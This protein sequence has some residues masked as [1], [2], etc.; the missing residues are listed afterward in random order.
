MA[1]WANVITAVKHY[2]AWCNMISIKIY[3][4]QAFSGTGIKRS[5]SQRHY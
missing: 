3:C 5:F 1:G 2:K 4:P